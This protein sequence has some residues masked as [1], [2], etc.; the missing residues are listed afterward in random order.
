MTAEDRRLTPRE[1]I[2]PE[3]VERGYFRPVAEAFA[4]FATAYLKVDH[5][6][7]GCRFDQDPNDPSKMSIKLDMNISFDRGEPRDFITMN[8]PI[9]VPL[10][11]GTLFEN[12]SP[13]DS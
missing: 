3:L 9:L 8:V 5:R 2:V 10:P 1:N 11:K 7:S 6:L 13:D 4:A 12:Q